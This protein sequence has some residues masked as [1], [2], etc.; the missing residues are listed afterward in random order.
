MRHGM[1]TTSAG[2]IDIWDAAGV[3]YRPI[4][5][6]RC[7]VATESVPISASTVAD[8]IALP[9]LGDVLAC[10]SSA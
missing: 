10:G 9:T 8:L 6:L 5:I 4:D 3:K 2:N 7:S 1:S